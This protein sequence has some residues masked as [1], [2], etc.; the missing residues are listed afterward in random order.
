MGAGFCAFYR[1]RNWGL[2]RLSVCPLGQPK[3]CEMVMGRIDVGRSFKLICKENIQVIL[4]DSGTGQP[5]IKS[6]NSPEIS[7]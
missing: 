5:K 7:L 6:R 4:N 1:W 3:A 2:E